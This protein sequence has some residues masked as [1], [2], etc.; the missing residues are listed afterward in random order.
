MEESINKQKDVDKRMSALRETLSSELVLD[1]VSKE[2]RVEFS[3][4]SSCVMIKYS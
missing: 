1:E 3:L 4:N 2:I